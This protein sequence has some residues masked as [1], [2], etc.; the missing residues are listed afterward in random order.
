MKQTRKT[1]ILY[2]FSILILQVSTVEISA[3]VSSSL[4]PHLFDE[5]AYSETY[6]L[7]FTIDKDKHLII[8]LSVSN[9]GLGDQNS[10][11]RILYFNKEETWT[12]ESF[13]DREMWTFKPPAFLKIGSCKF[14]IKKKVL[15]VFA[16]L[17]G[18]QF[19]AILYS[20]INY[21][22]PPNHLIKTADGFF[23]QQVL[24][25]WG[26]AE[27][28]IDLPDRQTFKAN[29]FGCMYRFWVTALPPDLFRRWI[30]VYGLNAHGSNLIMARF[31]PSE[32]PP[33]G[34]A[35]LSNSPEPGFLES[36][37]LIIPKNKNPIIVGKAGGIRFLITLQQLLQRHAPV[38]DIG[39]LGHLMRP[40]IGNPVTYTYKAMLRI[41]GSDNPILAIVE[42]TENERE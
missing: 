11:C 16:R 19:K 14:E 36:I 30:R 12:A 41:T 4:K 25:H 21:T 17:D 18:R 32:A 9:L 20:D 39:V 6:A 22:Q 10:M 35:W 34:W 29:G 28:M 31:S 26:K 27:V 13:Y 23:D 7:V 3:Q 8:Q 24:I 33:T 38:E 37:D 15:E 1:I 2:C 42:I 40:W 5:E